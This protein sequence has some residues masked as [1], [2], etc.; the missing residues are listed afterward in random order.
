MK[1][2]FNYFFVC[3]L[4]L[5][6]P[7]KAQEYDLTL[8]VTDFETGK[9]LSS[10]TVLINSSSGSGITSSEGVFSTSLPEKEYTLSLEY[11]GYKNKQLII[12]L[13]KDTLISVKMNVF[14]E[15]LSEVVVLAKKMNE[16]VETPQM[17]VFNI[18]AKELVKIPSAFGEFDV[19]KSITLMA[20]VNNAGDVSNGISVRGG[21]LDQN[22]ML[23]ESA[24][25]FNP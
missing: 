6:L 5:T 12:D 3:I 14:E 4:I 15:Q 16:N 9:P 11:T 2:I 18:T 1:E 23:Y 22:L 24:P 13:N 21:S 8:Y 17:G 25:V 20:G 19:L 7:L 10:L